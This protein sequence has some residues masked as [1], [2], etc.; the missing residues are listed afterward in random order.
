AEVPRERARDR[1]GDQLAEHA[2]VEEVRVALSRALAVAWMRGIGDGRQLLPDLHHAAEA[3][4]ELGRVRRELVLGDRRPEAAIDAHRAEEREARVL[5][6]RALGEDA[7]ARV[8]AP[9][10]QPL[11]A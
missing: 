5:L 10:D 11:P 8:A 1:L 3:L 9:V 7:L 4:G 2:R 6:E